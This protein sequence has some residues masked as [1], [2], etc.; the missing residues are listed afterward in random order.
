[1]TRALSIPPDAA[2]R[3][4]M[5]VSHEKQSKLRRSESTRNLSSN[6]TAPAQDDIAD[7]SDSMASVAEVRETEA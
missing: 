7:G 2:A 6:A 4:L 5:L 1:M 3:M